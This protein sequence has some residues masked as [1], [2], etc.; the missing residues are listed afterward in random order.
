MK[1]DVAKE[2]TGCVLAATRNMAS[3]R[4]T[5]PSVGGEE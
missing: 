1:S 3:P 5:I 2:K 4:G